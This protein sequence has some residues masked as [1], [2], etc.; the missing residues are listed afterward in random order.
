MQSARV[1]CMCSNSAGFK[2]NDIDDRQRIG[3]KSVIRIARR[4]GVS[5][6][7]QSGDLF[8]SGISAGI[9]GRIR[10]DV[11]MLCAPDGMIVRCTGVL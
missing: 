10:N 5:A 7:K 3:C 1:P 6:V 4:P 9:F 11:T 8:L 2:A